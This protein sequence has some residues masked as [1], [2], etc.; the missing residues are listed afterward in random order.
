MGE[1]NGV[2]LDALSVSANEPRFI[3]T[4]RLIHW[5]SALCFIVLLFTGSLLYF[6]SLAPLIG[7][8]ALIVEI[9]I[10]AGFLVLL[11]LLLAMIY[12]PSHSE[13][14]RRLSEL[15]SW[16]AFDRAWLKHPTKAA[17]YHGGR[18]NTG[19]KLNGAFFLSSL[20]AMLVSGLVMGLYIPLP[21]SDRQGATFL[22]DFGFYIMTIVFL[23]H[24][25]MVIRHRG[26]FSQ[27]TFLR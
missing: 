12:S 9:H 22:H 13:L 3:I 23:G 20:I 25:L 2:S 4:E 18:F 11:P 5:S 16:S 6:P 17:W 21:L 8:R 10:Y 26:S 7:N 27:M 14:R 1:S 15:A 24:L 19:Q